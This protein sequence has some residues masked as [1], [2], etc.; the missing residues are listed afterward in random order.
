[1]DSERFEAGE[2]APDIAADYRI[3]LQQVED[4]IR[5]EQAHAAA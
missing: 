3:E 4:A 5:C 2:S 1:M